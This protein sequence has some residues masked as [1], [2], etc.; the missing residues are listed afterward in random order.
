MSDIH[1]SLMVVDIRIVTV[2]RED[3]TIGVCCSG[4]FLLCG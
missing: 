2:I 4:V 1:E 3:S